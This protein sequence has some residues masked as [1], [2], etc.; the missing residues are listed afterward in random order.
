[1][2]KNTDKQFIVLNNQQKVNVT[3]GSGVPLP[4]L[5]SA[6]ATPERVWYYVPG[7]GLSD[8]DA[9]HGW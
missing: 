3:G 8:T 1:M 4:S 9:P 5:R 7:H 2:N 6:L